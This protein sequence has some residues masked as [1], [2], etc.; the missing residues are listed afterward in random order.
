VTLL[1]TKP[2]GSGD[3]RKSTTKLRWCDE[4]EEDVARDGCRN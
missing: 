3:R 1:R 2:G 4:L